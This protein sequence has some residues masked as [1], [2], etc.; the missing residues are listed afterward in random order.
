M[1]LYPIIA[2]ISE[3]V[4]YLIDKLAYKQTHISANY[5]MRL[6]FLTMCMSLLVYITVAEVPPPE[7]S[8]IALLLLLT[9]AVISFFGNF[10]DYLSLRTNN[11]ALRQPIL[12]ME[13]I[14][15]SFF[16]QIFFV[17]ERKTSFLIAIILS[18]V[19]MYI[20]YHKIHVTP[21]QRKGLRY[22]VIA[23]MIY[24]IGP[25]MYKITLP[26]VSPEYITFFRV[27]FI[28]LLALVFLP[29]KARETRHA[30]KKVLLGIGSGVLYAIGAVA[31]LYAIDTIGVTQTMLLLALAPAIVYLSAR[32]IFREDVLRREVIVSVCMIGIIL[33][34]T[35]M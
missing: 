9:I 14:L 15:A 5:I 22:L 26:Y 4:G 8:L 1:F 2:V 25:S 31:G 21:R 23:I 3:T 16:G 13:P 30:E 33:G 32:F 18:C 29:V 10:L 19:V 28:L 6:I 35:F 11:L 20:G 7:I 34:A 17:D 12:G 24:A 27:T